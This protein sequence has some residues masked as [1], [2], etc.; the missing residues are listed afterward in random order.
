[1]VRENT[2]RLPPA[3]VMPPPLVLGENMAGPP[4]PAPVPPP[5]VL[6]EQGIYSSDGIFDECSPS[7]HSDEAIYSSDDTFEECCP[8]QHGQGEQATAE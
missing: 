1:M 4:L 5:F 7:S 2:V 6:G 8:S 3:A